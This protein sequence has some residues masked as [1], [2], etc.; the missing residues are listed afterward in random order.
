MA[1]SPQVDLTP[2]RFELFCNGGND[3]AL[4]IK[5]PFD[6]TEGT[7]KL[8]IGATPDGTAFDDGVFAVGSGL[9]VGAYASGKTPVSIALS[10][11]FT[12]AHILAKVC[13]S[14][15]VILSSL[16]RGYAVGTIEIKGDLSEP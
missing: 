11:S 14:Y 2:P 7:H 6:A 5:L 8:L 10:R 15:T 4:V 1:N 12:I 13:F 16:K 9:T 3:V